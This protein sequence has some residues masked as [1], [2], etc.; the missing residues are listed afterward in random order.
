MLSRGF[1]DASILY[2][3]NLT[4]MFVFQTVQFY[5]KKGKNYFHIS[6]FIAGQNNDTTNSLN[7]ALVNYSV[8]YLNLK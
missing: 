3:P 2:D 6:N 1:K 8:K 4:I 7:N 5:I